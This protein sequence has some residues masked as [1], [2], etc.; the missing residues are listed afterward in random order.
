VAPGRLA[1]VVENPCNDVTYSV[2]AAGAKSACGGESR[3]KNSYWIPDLCSA[4]SGMTITVAAEIFEP[5]LSLRE[6]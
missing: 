2:I 1:A 6:Y 4:S 5:L 3:S